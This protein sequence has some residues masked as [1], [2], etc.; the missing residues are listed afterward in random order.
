MVA[1]TNSFTPRGVMCWSQMQTQAFLYQESKKKTN[2][3]QDRKQN[4][5]LDR[6]QQQQTGKHNRHWWRN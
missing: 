3:G 2:Q 4:E 5:P 1:F 6:Q